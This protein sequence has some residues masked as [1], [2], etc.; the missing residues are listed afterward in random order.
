MP[1]DATTVSVIG[2]GPMGAAFADAFLADG[3]SVTVWNRTAERAL[4]LA[5]RG[6]VV[7]PSAA[8]ALRASPLTVLVLT[9]TATA[10]EVLA[11]DEAAL[12]RRAIV[13]LSAGRPEEATALERWV[14]QRG[15]E[16]LD[17]RIGAYTRRIGSDRSNIICS[18]AREL[19]ERVVPVL[20]SA[21]RDIRHV[22]EDVAAANA[23][24]TSMATVFHH[25]ALAGF[26]EAAALADRY[27]VPV[28]EWMA[29]AEPMLELTRD[30]I[31]DAGEQCEQ[32]DYERGEAAIATHLATVAVAQQA[33]IEIGAEHALVDAT[34][35]YLRRAEVAGH[36][37]REFA[38]LFELLRHAPQ[39]D[40]AA[41]GG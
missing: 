1:R 31:L 36:G 13:N 29:M 20:R 2:L 33:M 24:S 27:G 12:D 30:A 3:H 39:F 6:A 17:G 40:S 10:R 18:G 41:Q 37:A 5:E 34:M 25:V 15:G 32:G 26:F 9:D 11:G 8:A 28:R 7:A 19:Y 35:G 23:V 16:Y 4:P 22:G 14:A 21:G 38:V